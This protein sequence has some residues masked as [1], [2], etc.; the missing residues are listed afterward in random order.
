MSA[1]GVQRRPGVELRLGPLQVGPVGA[2]G[3]HEAGG[4][5]GEAFVDPGL[6]PGVQPLVDHML[7]FVG[8]HPCVG[9][10]SK[11]YV[12]IEIDRLPS[13]AGRHDFLRIA[14]VPVHVAGHGRTEVGVQEYDARVSVHAGVWRRPEIAN[15]RRPDLLFE[16]PHGLGYLAG[17]D[18][19]T[20]F[21]EEVGVLRD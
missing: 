6:L 11:G 10:G 19:G 16:R 1:A 9:H 14:V 5:H 21:D 13:I 3:T 7:E 18:V 2:R 15:H 8:E 17:I 12:K 20:V 4:E